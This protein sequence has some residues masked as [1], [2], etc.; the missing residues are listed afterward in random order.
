MMRGQAS[1]RNVCKWDC[2]QSSYTLLVI[3]LRWNK[4]HVSINHSGYCR[5]T[6][7]LHRKLCNSRKKLFLKW[8]ESNQ[9]RNHFWGKGWH[10]Y[11]IF[12]RI[13]NQY[14]CFEERYS[15]SDLTCGNTLN[16]GLFWTWAADKYLEK[17]CLN[18]LLYLSKSME[19]LR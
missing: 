2:F 19:I 17:P 8:Q 4:K 13:P 1:D 7:K 5:C 12:T 15:A 10:L 11:T 6:K 14:L 16:L 9:L 3:K 18:I